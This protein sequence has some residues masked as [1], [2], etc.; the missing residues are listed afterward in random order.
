MKR[1]QIVFILMSGLVIM[2]QCGTAHSTI[3][4][5]L[6]QVTSCRADSVMESS[7]SNCRSYTDTCYA[8]AMVG[9]YGDPTTFKIRNCTACNAG[10]TL[11]EKSV[12]VGNGCNKTYTYNTCTG[13]GVVCDGT[14]DDCEST[15]WTSVGSNGVERRTQATCNTQTCVCSKMMEVRCAAGYYGT[16]LAPLEGTACTQC[17]SP[18]TSS[19][20]TQSIDGCCVNT[21]GTD[22]N[23]TYVYTQPCCY[24]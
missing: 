24:S 10:Y 13:S 8:Y 5:G 9:S 14:C 17:P 19:A 11:T 16:G 21:G 22:S 7:V 1:T 6:C 2:L 4:I 12:L 15:D 3:S 20:G 23:G 18:G